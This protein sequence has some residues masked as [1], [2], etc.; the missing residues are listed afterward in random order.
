MNGDALKQLEGKAL[1][2][3]TQYGDDPDSERFE[4]SLRQLLVSNDIPAER[5]TELKAM[6]VAAASTAAKVE[7]YSK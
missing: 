1:M 3:L 5:Y 7:W 6:V 4:D 2:L